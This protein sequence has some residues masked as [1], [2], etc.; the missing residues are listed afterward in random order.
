MSP[1]LTL[2]MYHP[3]I[4]RDAE[5]QCQEAKHVHAQL[6]L[7]RWI[8]P[9]I[10]IDEGLAAATRVIKN[11]EE[12][13]IASRDGNPVL[14]SPDNVKFL[15]SLQVYFSSRFV[16]SARRNFVLAAEMINADAAADLTLQI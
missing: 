3:S 14:L 13:M 7:D 6:L 5:M 4:F 9:G 11:A 12:L 16:M 15:N 2:A 10:H 8:E 1:R